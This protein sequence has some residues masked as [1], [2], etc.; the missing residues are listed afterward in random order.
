MGTLWRY[1]VNSI[2]RIHL[3]HLSLPKRSYYIP[4]VNSTEISVTRLPYTGPLQISAPYVRTKYT[5]HNILL[6]DSVSRDLAYENFRQTIQY[7][8]DFFSGTN[9]Y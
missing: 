6:Q 8:Q 9:H 2:R 5:N 1:T 7:L 3:F 4:Q